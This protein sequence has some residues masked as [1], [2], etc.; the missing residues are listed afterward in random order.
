MVDL[1]LHSTFS[2]GSDSPEA[3][4]ELAA[5][6]GLAAIALTDHDTTDGTERFL[7]AAA[8]RGIQTITGIELSV[9]GSEGSLHM[10]GYGI[11][12]SDAALQQ[13]LSELRGGR[14][15]RNERILQKLDNLGLPLAYES[16][17]AHAGNDEVVGRP[18]IAAAL[19]D[20]GYVATVQEAFEK[21]LIKGAPAYSD[22]LRLG[23]AR[24]IA[25]IRA[26][27]GLPVLA[28]PHLLRLKRKP[29]QKLVAQ[30]RKDGLAG[31]EVWHSQHNANVA[32][33]MHGL[34]RDLGLLVTGGSDYHGHLKGNIRIGVGPGHLRIPDECFAKLKSA[35]SAG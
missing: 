4:V 30:L 5:G 16:V 2:D 31:I 13:N 29:L 12:P 33:A 25:L 23:T 22:R 6:A 3:L 1:H 20:A 28:H 10:L 8:G 27:G 24:A 17:V 26:A 21:Y 15:S 19:V 18:H 32:A 9:E 11:D 35:L 34:A 14:H 7:A